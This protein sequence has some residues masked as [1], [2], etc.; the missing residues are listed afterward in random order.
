MLRYCQNQTNKLTY[1]VTSFFLGVLIKSSAGQRGLSGG[2][3]ASAIDGVG[4]VV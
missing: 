1:R 4:L 2:G 3:G